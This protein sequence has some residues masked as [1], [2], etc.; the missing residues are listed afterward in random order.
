MATGTPPSNHDRTSRNVL[1]PLVH[2]LVFPSKVK[3]LLRLLLT[4]PSYFSQHLQLYIHNIYNLHFPPSLHCW[5]VWLFPAPMFWNHNH[6]DCLRDGTLSSCRVLPPTPEDEAGGQKAPPGLLESDMLLLPALR[7]V[8]SRKLW[9]HRP[10]GPTGHLPTLGW[11][12]NPF[13]PISCSV[14]QPTSASS[15]GGDRKIAYKMCQLL[16]VKHSID[17]K[18]LRHFFFFFYYISTNIPGMMLETSKLFY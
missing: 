6:S 10:R 7:Q 14:K 9:W 3:P 13:K 15:Q 8:L 12:L 5:F 1:I 2:K 4:K 18:T 11:S 16:H 17:I